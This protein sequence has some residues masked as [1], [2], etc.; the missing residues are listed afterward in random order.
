MNLFP[1]KIMASP[2]QYKKKYNFNIIPIDTIVIFDINSFT[3]N[4]S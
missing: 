4:Y 1:M 3:F 2:T